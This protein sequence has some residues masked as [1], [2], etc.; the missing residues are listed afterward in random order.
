ME[1]FSAL[2]LICTT[3]WGEPRCEIEKLPEIH[4]DVRD[5]MRSIYTYDAINSTRLSKETKY[6]ISGTCL[7]WHV[8]KKK[9]DLQYTA[10]ESMNIIAVTTAGRYYPKLTNIIGR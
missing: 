5:C 10:L 7:K 9:H 2:V 1:L 6:I 4:N 3:S 8:Q